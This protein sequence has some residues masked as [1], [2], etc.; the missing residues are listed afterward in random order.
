MPATPTPSL[1]PLEEMVM[2][3]LYAAWSR[4]SPVF[5]RLSEGQFGITRREWRVLAAAVAHG[6]MTS[7]GLAAAAG[8]DL[9]R[10]SRALG[11]L[12]DKGWL[13]RIPDPRDGRVVHVHVTE[14]GHGLYAGLMPEILRLNDILTTD[15]S[16]EERTTLLQLL[17]KVEARG[18]Q[19]ADDN[20]VE[21]KAS[22]RLGGTRRALQGRP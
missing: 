11:T 20:L 14:A 21:A 15:L 17:R 6:P 5:V 10:T 2:F 7:A 4:A 22:R 18:Q 9:V 12:C 13:Q 8:L 3:R 16:T 1:P 19:M